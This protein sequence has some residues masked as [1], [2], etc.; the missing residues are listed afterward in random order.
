MLNSK[1]YR[2]KEKTE[3]IGYK[4]RCDAMITNETTLHKRPNDT[5]IDSY[6]SPYYGLQHE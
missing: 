6:R 5:G 2:G 1:M 4:K 3:N